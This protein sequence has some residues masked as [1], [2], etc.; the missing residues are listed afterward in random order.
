[1]PQQTHK[2]EYRF[3]RATRSLLTIWRGQRPEV[4]FCF[5][6]VVFFALLYWLLIG[7][8]GSETTWTIEDIVTRSVVWVSGQVLALLGV[9]ASTEG[10]VLKT[11]HFGVR[12]LS[13]CNGM[14]A[15]VMYGAAV[16]AYPT[17]L[18]AKGIALLVGLPAIQFVNV[19][20][21]LG[22]LMIGQYWPTWFH[23]AH[24]FWAQG[25]MICLVAAVWF[26]WIDRYGYTTAS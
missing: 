24:V 14:E 10:D 21:I 9:V 16:F 12:V 2:P 7:T 3:I 8:H 11:A 22:L 17:S 19:A 25:V 4:R 5:L 15:V 26:W 20:R 1:M 18:R 13:G 6:F 23:D